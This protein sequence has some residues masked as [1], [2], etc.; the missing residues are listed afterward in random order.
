MILAAGIG[1]A[2]Q[3]ADESLKKQA[4]YVTENDNNHGGIAE[5]LHRFCL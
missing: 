4:D 5:I 2:M 3:N 1:C